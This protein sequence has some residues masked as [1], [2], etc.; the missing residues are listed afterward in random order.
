MRET[1]EVGKGHRD[2]K[3]D[4]IMISGRH[5]LVMDFGVAKAVSEATGAQQLTTAGL[6]LG[7]PAY[8]A[9]EQAVADPKIDHR[10]DIYAVGALAYELLTGRPPFSGNTAQAVLSAHVTET[11]EPVTRY[12]SAVPPQLA[13]LV[14][15]CLEKKP[16]D[17]W[18]SAEEMLAQLETMATPIGGTTPVMRG[19]EAFRKPLR[20]VVGVVAALLVLTVG[21]MVVRAARESRPIAE[22]MPSIT[23]LPFA[24]LSPGREDQHLADGIAEALGDGLQNLGFRVQVASSFS[25]GGDDARTGALDREWNVDYLVAGSVL[26]SG[27]RVRITA[28]LN[29][30]D[31]GFQLWSSPFERE[32]E[33]I[34]DIYNDAVHAIVEALRIQL[35]GDTTRLAVQAP[36]DNQRAYDR[37][38]LGRYHFNKFAGAADDALAVRFLE[39]ALALDSNFA[40]AHAHLADVYTVRAPGMRAPAQL[41]AAFEQ[42]RRHANRALALDS[43]LA[44]AHTALG[45]V[46][47]YGDMDWDA[48]ARHYRRAIALDPRYAQAHQWYSDVLVVLGRI[49]EAVLRAQRAA[50]LDRFSPVVQWALARTLTI[51]RRYDEAESQLRGMLETRLDDQLAGLALMRLLLLTERPDEAFDRLLE[52]ATAVGEPDASVEALRQAYDSAGWNGILEP[53]PGDPVVPTL[54]VR[55]V[56]GVLR[57]GIPILDLSDTSRVLEQLECSFAERR[58]MFRKMTPDLVAGPDFDPLRANPRFQAIL[59]SLKVPRRGRE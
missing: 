28:R 50:E 3:P 37:Y 13:S 24:D 29:S 53:V 42:A 26:K 15:T 2:I 22:V 8:M 48:A 7:T 20:Q 18:Q 36:T 21:W 32:F 59:D 16:A 11:P 33:D 55:G 10:A 34:W 47:F 1:A 12:R 19:P 6:A 41:G 56:R 35:T 14:M 44:E 52:T 25:F 9:P 39:E 57:G 46:S 58:F 27:T 51:A 49:D 40:L 45:G 54:A 17:R 23:V 30:A 5:A 4:N 38:L 31:D 43:V